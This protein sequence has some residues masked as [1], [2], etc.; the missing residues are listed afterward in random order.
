MPS[1]VHE[2]DLNAL[3][4]IPLEEILLSLGAQPDPKDKHNWK[5]PM[6]RITVTGQ[7]FYN[8]DAEV[9]GGGAIDL[10]MHLRGV[11]FPR[12]VRFFGGI[13][14][15]PR[16]VQIVT[17]AVAQRT[18]SLVPFPVQENWVFVRD[19]LTRVRRISGGLIDSLQQDGVLYADKFKNAVF[20]SETGKGAELR[21]TGSGSFHGYR[22]EKAA[23]RLEGAGTEIAF[24]ESAI[25][26]LSLREHFFL[27]TILS[28][29]GCAK[30][31][32][33]SYGRAAREKGLRVFAAFDND[34]AGE[35]F[36]A[37]LKES[38][39]ASERLL[40]TEKDWNEDLLKNARSS[41]P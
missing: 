37:A 3:R 41:F 15:I 7:K 11:D 19:Y 14:E 40:P 12:A 29:G 20:V 24:V 33:Q 31:L 39:P 38:V 23:F 16:R 17:P 10:V 22:G 26:A 35:L 13:P 27:G 30:G 4:N 36:V 1:I 32:I 34:S 21:G 5:T 18:K 6:G 9:G 8:H 2:L 28:F 25:D